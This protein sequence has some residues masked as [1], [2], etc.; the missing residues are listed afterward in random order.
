MKQQKNRVLQ[1]TILL[2]IA[3]LLIVCLS[4]AFVACDDGDDNDNGNNIN[5]VTNDDDTNYD[6]PDIIDVD[7]LRQTLTGIPKHS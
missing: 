6:I 1:K 5:D 3:T 4:V 2:L 7:I